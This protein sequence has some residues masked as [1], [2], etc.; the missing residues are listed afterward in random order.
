MLKRFGFVF[1][2]LALIL[3]FSQFLLPIAIADIL[4]DAMATATRAE[5]TDAQVEKMPALL[6]LA[7]NFDHVRVH[8]EAAKTDKITFDRFDVEMKQVKI[9]MYALV[10]TRKLEE[11][12]AQS[13]KVEA[14]V[15]E[16]ELAHAINKS[17]KGAKDAK[18]SITPEK[19][20]AEGVVSIGGVINAK[21]RLEGK[22]VSQDGKIL[23]Q[24]ENFQINHG[25]VG[26]LGGKMMTDLV[27]VDL[28]E[29]P[30]HVTVKNITLEQGRAVIHA[31]NR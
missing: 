15:S 8:A 18:V 27:L 28:V 25:V 22:I 31:D 4:G 10:R 14:V 13:V 20:T 3:F 2:V 21:V 17:V 6:M 30:F 11:V 19:V 12:S 1:V 9:D 16:N 5:K 23:L 29:L 24:T 7:G 26:K